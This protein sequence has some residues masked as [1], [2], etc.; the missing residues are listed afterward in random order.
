MDDLR[1]A[2]TGLGADA[3]VAFQHEHL[4]AFVGQGA[5]DPQTLNACT[6]HDCFNVCRHVAAFPLELDRFTWTHLGRSKFGAPLLHRGCL[7]TLAR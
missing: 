3:V 7:L 5:R 2:R 4:L 6:H 1:I